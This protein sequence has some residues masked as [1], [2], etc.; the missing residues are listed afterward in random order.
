MREL[1]RL[2]VFGVA[3]VPLRALLIQSKP[4]YVRNA[5]K[6]KSLAKQCGRKDHLTL[7]I[8]SDLVNPLSWRCS[9]TGG[10]PYFCNPGALNE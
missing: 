5:G 7:Y 10:V 3:T 4:E 6:Q 8:V 1:Q 9:N 2:A